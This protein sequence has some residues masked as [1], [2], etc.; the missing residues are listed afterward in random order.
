MDVTDPARYA[1]QLTMPEI[2]PEGQALL[3]KANVLVVGAGGLGSPALFYLV[4]AG[5]GHI[6][7]VDCDQVSISNLQRQI[8]YTEADLGKAKALAAKERLQALN[9]HTTITA[10]GQRLDETNA[11]AI[12]RQYNMVIDATDNYPS[13]CLLDEATIALQIPLIHGAIEG[14]RGQCAVLN[15][16]PNGSSYRDLFPTAPTSSA[17]GPIG[18]LGTTAGTLGSIQASQAIQLALGQRPSLANKLLVVDLWRGAWETYNTP[19]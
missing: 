5:I 14:F 4:A 16:P 1:R 17:Q 3:A 8:L 19:R 10:Y 12:A 13:R 18:V 11:Q 6:G 15:L 9:R 2:G 7:I